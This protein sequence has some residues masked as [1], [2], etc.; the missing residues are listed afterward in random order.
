MARYRLTAF[1]LATTSLAAASM[2]QA[3]DVIPDKSEKAIEATAPAKPARAT[4]LDAVTTTATRNAES[5]NDVPATVSVID[6]EELERMNARNPRDVIRYEPGVSVGNQPLRGGATSY[7]IRGIGDNRVLL[8][9]DGL[10]VQDMPES[11]SASGGYTRD[12]VD[13]DNLKRVEIVRG[14]ASALYGSD[15][16]GGIVSYVTKDPSDYLDLVGKDWFASIKGAYGSADD[17]FAETATGAVR[18]GDFEVLGLYTRRDGHEAKPNGS[19]SGDAL[20]NPQDYSS[21]NFLGK[22]VFSPTMADTLKLTGE[23]TRKHQFTNIL[24]EV[25][26]SVKSSTSKDD[27][28]RNRVSIDYIHDAPIGFIDRSEFKVFY[29]NLDRTEHQEQ[30]RSNG[31]TFR[32]TDLGFGQ[33]IFGAEAQFNSLAT[34]LGLANE[35]TY[36]LNVEH[37]DTERPRDRTDTNTATLVSTSLICTGPGMCELFPNKTFPDNSLLKFGTYVQDK[38]ALGR[39]TVLPGVRLDYYKMTPHP[40]QLFENSNGVAVEEFSKWHA[41]PKLGLTYDLT[42]EYTGFAQ[43]A[44]GF[45]IPPYD[46]AN[47]SFVNYSHFYGIISNPDLKPEQ[48]DGVEF[49]LRGKYASGSSFSTSVFYNRY[50]DFIETVTLPAGTL[51]G[52]LTAF[53]YQN[54]SNV[55]IYGAE[56]RGDYRFL[57]EWA[58]VGSI[59]YAYGED[60]DTHQ[61]ID[62]VDPVKLVTGLK[63]QSENWGAEF[64]ATHAWR[65]TRVSEATYFNAPSYTVLDLTAYVEVMPTFTVNAGVFNLTD[66]KYFISQDVKSIASTSTVIDRYAQVGRNFGVN[67]TLRF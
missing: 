1:L 61:S 8:L 47:Q 62:S 21:D 19:V 25:T 22:L 2:A 46:S 54:L 60:Q 41:S 66:E 11:N 40:D 15:A 14:P 30:L 48:S 33:E 55:V 43:Y 65:H 64:T 59:A 7:T 39:F 58:L 56:A 50:K 17:S 29:T 63:Y 52:G 36:G 28:R 44:H 32:V 18:A 20:Y 12:F 26:G 27:T 45:R 24:T 23:F 4:Q 57:P 49:G 31:A 53:Q 9:I 6:A 10:D 42:E 38:V 34:L 37:S 51:P 13:L 67:A 3:A 35:F 5:L 16:L